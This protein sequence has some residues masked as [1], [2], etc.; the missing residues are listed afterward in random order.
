M[1]VRSNDLTRTLQ[2]RNEIES[3]YLTEISEKNEKIFNLSKEIK[4]GKFKRTN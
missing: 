1:E 4:D 2:E 3:R